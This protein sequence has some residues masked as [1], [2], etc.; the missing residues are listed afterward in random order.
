MATGFRRIGAGEPRR[1]LFSLETNERRILGSLFADSI[2]L[3]RGDTDD[4]EQETDE[5]ARLVGMGGSSAPPDDPALARL[6]PDA[7]PGDPERSAEFRQLTENS[8]RDVKVANLQTALLTLR[9][10]DPTELAA[11][12]AHSWLLALTDV[13]LIVSSR[14]GIETEEDFTEYVEKYEDT[15]GHEAMFLSVYDFLTW[16]QE[17]LSSTLLMELEEDE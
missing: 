3:L 4:A 9:R 7:A 6:L 8:V 14:M 11:S 10:T 12:E 2:M 5:L 1:Y 15:D 17:S 13:R 16:L